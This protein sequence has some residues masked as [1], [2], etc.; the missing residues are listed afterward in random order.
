MKGARPTVSVII[1]SYNC[2]LYIAET[3]ESILD[4]T[5]KDIEIIVVD[6]GSTDKTRQI[7]TS[8]GAPVR[9]VTQANAGVCAARNRGIREAAGQYIC[10]MD[11][12]DYWLPD[13]LAWQLEQMQRHPEV[14]LVYSTFAWW[15]PDPN[16][17]FPDPRNYKDDSSCAVIDEEF[18]GW[19]YHLLL[20]DCWVLTSSALIRAEVFDKCG[21][22]DE[23]LP[24]SED[25]DLWL[26]IAREYSFIKL[27]KALTLY[28]QHPRQG[29]RTPR[30]IDY[31]TELLSRAV[32]RWGL[33]SPD[34][35][36]ITR[37]QF[38]ETISRYHMEFG[39]RHLVAGNVRIANHS[40]LKSWLASPARLKRLAYIPAGLL[41]WRPKW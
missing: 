1:P 31:R 24:Y 36:C 18:S 9:L 25:W 21:S 26:R 8:Y 23:S 13:K 39:I 14:A 35:R 4:Q 11:H 33:C 3:L 22:F 17:V 40:F 6:D 19:I 34:G 15:N 27:K 32:A 16:G 10:L 20:L 37:R 29:N 5:F 12:D 30:N 38:R 2:E 7:V 41:G 28:R